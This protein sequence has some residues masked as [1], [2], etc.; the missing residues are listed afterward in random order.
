VHHRSHSIKFEGE[1]G[2]K[3]ISLV[4]AALA[5]A[6]AA[7]AASPAGAQQVLRTPQEV[8][9]CLCAE[10]SVSNLANEV[11][12]RNRIYEERR[13]QVETLENEV[14]QRRGQID[15]NNAAAVEEF[16]KLLSRRDDAVN[17]FARDVTPDY[18]GAVEQYNR[19]VATYNQNCSG[20]VY[21]P[22]VLA[23]VRQSLVC[24]RQ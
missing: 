20:K 1:A 18:A 13:K 3:G 22:D 5:L 24:P 14:N 4:V 12:A 8:T 23:Q 6:A 19:Q 21:D 2:M 10:Q 11:L 7:L 17:A 16:R 15:P 9:S